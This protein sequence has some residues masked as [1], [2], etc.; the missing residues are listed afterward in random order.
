VQTETGEI[1]KLSY[2]AKGPFQITKV[3]GYNP[4]EVQ[5]YD[6]PESAVR[7]Y[8]GTELYFL[9]PATFPHEPLDMMDERYLNYSHITLMHRLYRH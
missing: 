6:N 9:P 5:G 2:Q 3:L 4:Y 1:G 8:K 7:K